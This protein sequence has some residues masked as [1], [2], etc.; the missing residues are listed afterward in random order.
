MSFVRLAMTVSTSV[1]PSFASRANMATAGA[2]VT[3]LKALGVPAW[4]IQADV[5]RLV[6]IEA[7]MSQTVGNA[8]A[9]T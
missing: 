2:T 1:P 4:G 7:M 9:A 8:G 6:D 3:E 5:S